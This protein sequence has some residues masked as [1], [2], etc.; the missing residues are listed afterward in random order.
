MEMFNLYAL[1][2][3]PWK[4]INHSTSEVSLSATIVL[5]EDGYVIWFHQILDIFKNND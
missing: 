3:N 5:T 2:P 1:Q 4:T